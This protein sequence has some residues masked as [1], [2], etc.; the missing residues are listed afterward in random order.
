MITVCKNAVDVSL[1][2]VL[3]SS[4]IFIFASVNYSFRPLVGGQVSVEMHK[5]GSCKRQRGN[6]KTGDC[7]HFSIQGQDLSD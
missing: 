3:A 6:F 2:G 5:N 1:E 4:R 7:Q